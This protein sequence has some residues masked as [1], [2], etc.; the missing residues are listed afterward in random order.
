MTTRRRPKNEPNN[1]TRLIIDALPF[2]NIAGDANVNDLARS[3]APFAA[4]IHEN[5]PMDAFAEQAVMTWPAGCI[6]HLRE[7]ARNCADMIRVAIIKGL[8]PADRHLEA[9]INATLPLVSGTVRWKRAGLTHVNKATITRNAPPKQWAALIRSHLA[10]FIVD[11]FTRNDTLMI[12]GD[13]GNAFRFIGACPRCK[14]LFT[15]RRAN[16]EYDRGTCRREFS[17]KRMNTTV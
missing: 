15:K 11:A 8:E 9:W 13:H 14:K 10:R 7:T 6:E 4:Q 5:A 16:Q 1:Y 17:R 2:L 12:E 3:V